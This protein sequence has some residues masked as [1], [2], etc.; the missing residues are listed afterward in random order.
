MA[1]L[2]KELT[3]LD[4]RLAEVFS[5]LDNQ[6]VLFSHPVYQYLQRHYNINGKSVHWEPEQEL[7]T[8]AWIAM[9]QIIFT[10]SATVM[11]WEDDPLLSTAQRLSDVGITSVH[12]HTVANRPEQG[13]YLSVMRANMKRIATHL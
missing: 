10:H 4:S 3:Q 13:D 1:R 6:P 7:T 11:I 12:F 5:R 9:Q 2:E 8:S